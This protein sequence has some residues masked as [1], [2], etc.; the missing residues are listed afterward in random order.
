LSSDAEQ[1]GFAGAVA[2]GEYGAF[3]GGNFEGNAAESEEP[4]IAFID[5]LEEETGWR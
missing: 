5:A 1:G 2:S 4:A 3:A